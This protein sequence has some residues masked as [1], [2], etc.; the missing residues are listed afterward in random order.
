MR[1]NFLSRGYLRGFYHSVVYDDNH[2]NWRH[3]NKLSYKIVRINV[4]YLEKKEPYC[5]IDSRIPSMVTGL[6]YIQRHN[7]G[8]R[9][10]SNLLASNHKL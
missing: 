7:T 1:Y 10:I 9:K 5:N 8:L 6:R 3:G 2:I 4:A